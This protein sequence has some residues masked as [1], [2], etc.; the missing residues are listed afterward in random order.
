MLTSK[1]LFDLFF[2]DLRTSFLFANMIIKTKN[3]LFDPQE[4][5]IDGKTR[6]YLKQLK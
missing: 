2:V 1:L 3:I 6:I 4:Y 5:G